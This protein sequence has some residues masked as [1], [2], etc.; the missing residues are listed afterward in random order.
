MQDLALEDL[1]RRHVFF[2][3]HADFTANHSAA[4]RMVHDG[5]G[6]DTSRAPLPNLPSDVAIGDLDDLL[7][8]VKGR[9]TLTVAE[10]LAELRTN[11]E[12]RRIQASVLD[13]V[14][15]LDQLHMTLRHELGRRL[16]FELEASDARTALA[17]ARAELAG[18]QAGERRAR[19]LALHD[20]LTS[21]PNR[22]CFREQLDQALSQGEPQRRAIAVMYLDLDGFKPVNDAHGH[23]AG[24]ELLRIVAARLMRAVRAED[25]VS[26]LGGDEFA[27]LL[28]GM[29]SREHLSQLARKLFLAVSAPVTI[30]KLRL[31]VRPSIGIALCPDDGATAESLLK[32]ADAAMYRAK[33]QQTGYAFFN[34][35]TDA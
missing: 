7:G 24:D 15:A 31:N 27:C 12:A 32:N 11:D 14:D 26:R 30:G 6:I 34:Q 23:D 8:A 22:S 13:C 3:A 19:H 25:T 21:L 10:P 9:L 28:D 5:P 2:D 16:E 29:S 18:T 33:R 35:C 17:L 4:Q 20:G 1:M